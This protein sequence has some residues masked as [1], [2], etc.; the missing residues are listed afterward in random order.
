M[1]C[2]YK[3]AY[4]KNVES[5]SKHEFIGVPGIKNVLVMNNHCEPLSGL[6]SQIKD[7]CLLKANK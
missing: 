6:Q 2:L 7:N 5:E 1:E 3:L 4:Y